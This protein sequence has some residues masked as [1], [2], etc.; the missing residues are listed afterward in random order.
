MSSPRWRKE[1][2]LKRG[3]PI[4]AMT[5]AGLLP[6]ASVQPTVRDESRW[7]DPSDIVAEWERVCLA[8]LIEAAV[9]HLAE[10]DDLTAELLDMCDRGGRGFGLF[11]GDLLD[12]P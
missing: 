2:P 5:W 6:A 1:W 12:Q 3:I 8:V 11:H 4:R 7:V 9:E 10:L